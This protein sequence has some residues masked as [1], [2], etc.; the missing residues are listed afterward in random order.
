MLITKK[1]NFRESIRCQEA[2]IPYFEA[3]GNYFHLAEAYQGLIT[4]YFR[5]G[6]YENAVPYSEKTL[7]LRQASGERVCQESLY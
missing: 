4:S 1:S 6:E 2:S 7:K 3:V 5:L